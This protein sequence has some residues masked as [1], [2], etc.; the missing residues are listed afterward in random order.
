MIKERER[1]ARGVSLSSNSDHHQRPNVASSLT[2]HANNLNRGDDSMRPQVR[3]PI[4][5]AGV[6]QDGGATR[7]KNPWASK[8]TTST[9]STST[10]TSTTDQT[11]PW[12][13]SSSS[14]SSNAAAT[15][16]AASILRSTDPW[17]NNNNAKPVSSL[18]D[19]TAIVEEH[20]HIKAK[21][22][23]VLRGSVQP[24][25]NNSDL[26]EEV[27]DVVPPRCAVNSDRI[28]SNSGHH[29]CSDSFNEDPDWQ[30]KQRN[31][32]PR[33]SRTPQA[34]H[35]VVQPPQP[36]VGAVSVHEGA[37]AVLQPATLR[38]PGQIPDSHGVS[39]N[40]RNA[41]MVFNAYNPPQPAPTV[42]NVPMISN[43][44]NPPQPAPRVQNAP[45]VSNDYNPRFRWNGAA[46]STHPPEESS[47]NK[48]EK[49]ADIGGDVPFYKT[50]MFTIVCLAAIVAVAVVA[51]I[52]IGMA[53]SGSKVPKTSP[54]TSPR[55]TSPT[56]SPTESPL[57]PIKSAVVRSHIINNGI[58]SAEDL[59]V[60]SSPQNKAYKWIVRYD[61]LS[62]VSEDMTDQ[63]KETMV[64]RYSLAVYYYAL[65]GQNWDDTQNWLYS[66]E[67]HCEWVHVWCDED[68][69]IVQ[70]RTKEGGQ[71]GNN[72]QLGANNLEGTLPSEI[73]TLPW[74]S[75]FSIHLVLLLSKLFHTLTTFCLIVSFRANPTAWQSN[76]EY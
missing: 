54:P 20:E 66:F 52:G 46:G 5:A 76:Q 6:P 40:L 17:N 73:K 35:N 70:I 67:P 31:R 75:M 11:N 13:S 33:A 22:K 58:S 49:D 74:L 50:K 72:P 34:H 21:A 39:A 32:A 16:T 65:G 41:P 61:D 71:I 36:Q 8:P 26:V 45:M 30:I 4:V 10:S 42:Q 51:G 23:R 9:T 24:V 60:S 64:I 38:I 62:R 69:E 2:D 3:E 48:N 28:N 56:T 43:D 7:S 47:S 27:L 1:R 12:S 53:S 14:S 15:N 59:N 68:E 19:S 44:Y 63:E 18:R 55:T 25:S 37:V 57:D 29:R